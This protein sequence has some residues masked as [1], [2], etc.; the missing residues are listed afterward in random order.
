M[1]GAVG[2]LKF[3]IFGLLL[4]GV[5]VALPSL[6]EV[7][8]AGEPES[9]AKAIRIRQEVTD[10]RFSPPSNEVMITTIGRDA[11]RLDTELDAEGEPGVSTIFRVQDNDLLILL[12]D[13]EEALTH[14]LEQQEIIAERRKFFDRRLE[15]LLAED[16]TGEAAEFARMLEMR[17]QAA[18]LNADKEK[19]NE[20]IDQRFEQTSE[21]G[22]LEGYPWTKYREIRNGVLI[23][24]LLVSPWLDIGIGEDVVRVLE[25]LD[26]YIEDSKRI[27]GTEMGM[28]NPFGQHL[29]LEGVPLVIRQFDSAGNVVVEVRVVSIES[30]EE[31]SGVFENPGYPES[32][33]TDN[34][35]ELE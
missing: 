13:T 18:R 29:E 21:S 15:E 30:V 7:A 27:S 26:A 31:S 16:A 33:T 23:Q 12:H 24:E 3:R 28:Q 10:S 25:K 8:Q 19:E 1:V 32:A 2:V 34:L 22:E 5:L 14:N 6:P 17:R 9:D 35:P 11:L 20:G 4:S